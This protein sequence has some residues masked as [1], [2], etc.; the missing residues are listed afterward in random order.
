MASDSS[1]S[2]WVMENGDIPHVLAVDDNI[3]DRTLVEKLLKNSSCKVTTA[4]NGLKALEYLGL[5][6]G[7][8]QK[9]TLENG[10]PKVNLIITDYCMPGMTGYELLKKIKQSSM[11]EV[12]VVI[13][14]SDNIPT[15]INKCMEEGAQM[16]LS[17]PVKQSDVKQLIGQLMNLGRLQKN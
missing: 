4:E 11:K 2:K 15:R 14:S 17:K 7:A 9:N 6:S 13:M 1:S 12:P 16:F 3:I 8:E 10:G 5:A